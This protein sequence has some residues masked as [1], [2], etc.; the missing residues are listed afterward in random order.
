MSKTIKDKDGHSLVEVYDTDEIVA[1]PTLDG[2][3]G[4]LV[5]LKIGDT[6]YKVTGGGGGGKEYYRYYIYGTYNK[7]TS[8]TGTQINSGQW[9]VNFVSELN[10]D[11]NFDSFN[12]N[13]LTDVFGYSTET[14]NRIRHDFRIL[15]GSFYDGNSISYYKADYID[16]LFDGNDKFDGFE[17]KNMLYINNSNLSQKD[18]Q[19]NE[20]SLS[21]IGTIYWTIA[22]VGK[23]VMNVETNSN[24]TEE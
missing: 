23:V 2:S 8:A 16:G 17:F 5:G 15:Y 13:D 18:I 22:N 24:D 20:S 3:E 1:N 11:Y 9:G 10:L 14:R 19:I 12:I 4:S 7:T 6:K 21:S